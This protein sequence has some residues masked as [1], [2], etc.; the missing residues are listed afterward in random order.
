[1]KTFQHCEHKK[2]TIEV[3]SAVD[4]FGK[5]FFI[6]KFQKSDGSYDSVAFSSMSSVIDFFQTNF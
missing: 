5:V 6:V 1:M 4:R 2:P 3:H